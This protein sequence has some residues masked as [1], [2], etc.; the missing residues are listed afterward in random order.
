M[1]KKIDAQ[2]IRSG[3]EIAIGDRATRR[4]RFLDEHFPPRGEVKFIQKVPQ[5]IICGSA[6]EH[7]LR[8]FTQT[9][10]ADVRRRFHGSSIRFLEGS[11]CS[12]RSARSK[13]TPSPACVNLPRESDK[14]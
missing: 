14:P 8:D 11:A 6:R 2:F 1:T 9:L 10:R 4:Q 7:A 12:D 3:G 13:Q 5:R